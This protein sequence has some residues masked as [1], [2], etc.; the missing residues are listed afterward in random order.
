M[1]LA[2]AHERFFPRLTPSRNPNRKRTIIAQVLKCISATLAKSLNCISRIIAKVLKCPAQPSLPCNRRSCSPSVHSPMTVPLGDDHLTATIRAAGLE[3][4]TTR[5]AVLRHV[6]ASRGAVAHAEVVAALGGS[7]DRIT[8]YRTLVRLCRAGILSRSDVGDRVW[9]FSLAR[10]PRARDRASAR[11]V[12]SRCGATT[13]ISGASVRLAT[14]G[15]VPEAVRTRRIE[16]LLV[17]RCDECAHV[18]RPTAG[19]PPSRRRHG[20]TDPPKRVPI[21]VPGRRAA[22]QA[23]LLRTART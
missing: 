8:I 1:G 12:C 16:V 10:D 5:V 19:A 3:V 6:L 17:G 4:T 14:R 9:R 22:S 2:N 7:F 20:E 23:T 21:S 11:F 13:Y 15:G 18:K